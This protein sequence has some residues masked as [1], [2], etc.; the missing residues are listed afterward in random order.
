[1]SVGQRAQAL[2]AKAAG[3]LWFWLAWILFLMVG[4]IVGTIFR[5]APERLPILSEVDNFRLVDQNERPYG[6]A[7]LRGRVW[8]ASLTCTECQYGD[9]AFMKQLY[10]VQHR[11]RGLAQAFRIVTF[12]LDPDQDSPADLKAWAATHRASL[13]RW[14]FL[15]GEPDLARQA[16]TEVFGT[17]L[18]RGKPG[19]KRLKAFDSKRG[20][21]LALVDQRMRVRG[22]YDVRVEEDI[23]DLI[24]DL[25]LVA[26]RG[27]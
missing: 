15:T 9:P 2:A 27:D 19:Q 13:S 26:N 10:Q 14:V 7:E 8:V 23:Q 22:Y 4:A 25:G 17:L 24:H 6:S 16:V 18:P 5:D 21:V 3:N 11:T 12:T 1:M 20:W